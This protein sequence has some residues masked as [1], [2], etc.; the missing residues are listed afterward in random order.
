[1]KNPGQQLA[2][3]LAAAQARGATFDEAFAEAERALRLATLEEAAKVAET[4]EAWK[5]FP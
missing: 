2:G 3:F 5:P 1:M 4:V